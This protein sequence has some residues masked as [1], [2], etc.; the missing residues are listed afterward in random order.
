[1]HPT[2]V[3]LSDDSDVRWEKPPNSIQVFTMPPLLPQTVTEPTP[4]E[5]ERLIK[6]APIHE[7]PE[8]I[9]S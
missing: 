6:Q 5:I 9:I 4:V 2:G 7:L 8:L 1:V 3:A